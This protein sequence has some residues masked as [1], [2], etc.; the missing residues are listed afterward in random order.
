MSETSPA[1]H[2]AAS[3][4]ET[5]RTLAA[6]GRSL[7]RLVAVTVILLSVFMAIS[8]VKDD[9]IVQ[10]MQQAKAEV[11]DNWAEY[12]AAKL[13]QHVAD[14]AYSR[15]TIFATLPGLQNTVIRDDMAR[16]Q[17]ASDR[18][19][20][21]AADMMSKARLA[22]ARVEQLGRMDDQF[23]MSDA[24]IAI[25]LAISATSILVES[26]FILAASW[27]FGAAGFVMGLVGFVGG[28]LRIEW[29]IN[30]LN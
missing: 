16:Q 20:A 18:Y 3:D 19:Q 14:E 9:N 6:Q 30:L 13:K 24:L 5:G 12:Q 28:S 11:V 26:Y 2:D 22:E 25:A 17:V 23:D 15:D 10:T 8:K 27:A 29:L 1:M 4:A 21:R 7:S